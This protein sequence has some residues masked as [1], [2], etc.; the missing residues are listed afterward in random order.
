M[1]MSGNTNAF[2]IIQACC[3][4]LF[5]IFIQT[6]PCLP[7]SSIQKHQLGQNHSTALPTNK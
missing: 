6:D 1:H 4:Y 7:A 5:Y 3:I 2:S